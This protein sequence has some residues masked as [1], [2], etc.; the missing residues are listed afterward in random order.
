MSAIHEASRHL[1]T[2]PRKVKNTKPGWNKYVADHQEAAKAAHRTWIIAGRPRQGPDLEHKKLANARYKYAVR[3]IAKHEQAV[4]AHSMAE[5]LLGN[6]VT[7]FWKE[8]KATNRAKTV[9][10][11]HIG[12]CIWC[13]QYSRAVEAAL[14]SSV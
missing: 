11:C 12:R 1:H 2:H 13:R 8:V 4:R 6:N 5:N 3:F 7:E 10:P 9:L 14:C